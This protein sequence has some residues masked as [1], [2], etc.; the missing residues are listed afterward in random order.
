MTLSLDLTIPGLSATDQE[1]LNRLWRQLNAKQARN[2]V[3]RIYYDSK[4]ALKD[5]GIAI[6]PSLRNLDAVLGWP[7][8]AVDKLA[9]RT[10]LDGFVLPG[11]S[12]AD[13]GLDDLWIENRLDIEAPQAHI[14]GLLHACAFVATTLGDTTAGEPKV[15]VTAHSA[16]HATGLWDPRRRRLSAA[17]VVVAVDNAGNVSE[18]VMAL[19]D[20][21]LSMRHDGTKWDV[22]AVT[23]KLGRV[24]VEPLVYQPRLGRP[25]GKSRLTRPVLYLADSALRTVV[26]SEVGA[27]FFSAPQRYAMGADETAFQDAD[28]KPRGQWEAVIGRVWAIERDDEGEIPVVGQFP[29]VSMQPHSE[30]LRMWAMLYAGETSLPVSS[31]GIIQDNPSSAEAIH[32]SMEDLITEAEAAMTT[33]GAGWR[34]TALTALQLRD[35]LEAVP[36]EWSGLRA[37]WRN[38][39]TPSQAQSAD[40]AAKLVGAGILPPDSEVTYE[41][42]GFDQT[43]IARL[44]ED[45]RRAQ[46]Q[47]RLTALATAAQSARQNP[48]VA[49][50]SAS[51][52]NAE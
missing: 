8:K 24:P 47:D 12:T 28:G 5:L 27:E 13:L 19:P 32:A 35:D 29:Q 26:R 14:S 43:T 51:R 39:A 38:P 22:R 16:E 4:N 1:T 31:L 17:L 21:I 52:G 34:M 20:K 18:L 3:R 49:Q 6:P 46:A 45:K 9:E 48:A 10:H 50:M 44:I 36:K 2:R 41:M 11:K 15:I 33:F 42:L 40:A 7:A 30:H 25:F 37:K 23:H